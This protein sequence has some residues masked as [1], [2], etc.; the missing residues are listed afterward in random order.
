MIQGLELGQSSQEATSLQSMPLISCLPLKAGKNGKPSYS[1]VKR[2]PVTEW[3][4]CLIVE[5]E[6]CLTDYG[7]YDIRDPRRFF[8]LSQPERVEYPSPW[9][10]FTTFSKQATLLGYDS[11]TG[12]CEFCAV[13]LGLRFD[14]HSAWLQQCVYRF[15]LK[16]YRSEKEKEKVGG[17]AAELHIRIHK[18]LFF[19]NNTL[20]RAFVSMHYI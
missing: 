1:G 2:I 10:Y 19:L 16:E 9:S 20:N 14:E 18:Y 11:D 6:I 12:D 17:K 7:A 5:D 4:H 8:S 3:P 13:E 15:N